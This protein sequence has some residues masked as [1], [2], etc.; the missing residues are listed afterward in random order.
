MDPE[1][2]DRWAAATSHLPYLTAAALAL[3]TPAEASPLVG[4]GYVST[5]RVAAT[6]ASIMV[7]VL[8]TNR[9][10]IINSINRLRQQLDVL[11]E[12]LSSDEIKTLKIPLEKGAAL[13]KKIIVGQSGLEDTYL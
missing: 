1:T 10:N 7:E 11:E 3:A 9:G 4:P 12:S 13:R 6:P 2:H 5:T 8:I